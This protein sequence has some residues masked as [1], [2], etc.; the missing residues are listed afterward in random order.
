M[1]VCSTVC[2]NDKIYKMLLVSSDQFLLCTQ[3]YFKQAVR[4][5]VVEPCLLMFQQME[6][7][8]VHNTSIT[9]TTQSLRV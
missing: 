6:F 9:S 3:L 1:F 7:L 2:G 5:G 4:R 8:C